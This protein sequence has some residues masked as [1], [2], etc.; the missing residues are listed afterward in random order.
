MLGAGLALT[1]VLVAAIAASSG[2]RPWDPQRLRDSLV[3][4]A[5][6]LALDRQVR[7]AKQELRR[8]RARRAKEHHAIAAALALT[9]Y[10]RR[11]G[12]APK[13]AALTFDDGP[14]PF[15]ERIL[16]VLQREHVKATF[17]V[18]GRQ[19]AGNEAP[20]QREVAQGHVVADHTWSH[21]ALTTLSPHDQALEIDSQADA[22]QRAG[23]PRPTL[24]RPPFGLYNTETLKILRRRGMLSVLWTVD[25]SDYSATATPQAVAKRV[26]AETEA[27]GIVLMHDAGGNRTATARSLTLIIRGLRK[28]G[29]QLVTV[30][31]LLTRTKIARFQEYVAPSSGA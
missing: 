11:G 8:Q 20:L 19:L 28:R 26:L 30:P 5:P 14:G 7:L 13:L 22:I 2:G 21:K 23:I 9:P 15:T 27:G 16:D 3:T 24:F 1:A 18:L 31:Q 6:H 25:T 10:V 29:F 12:S 17:F 4:A